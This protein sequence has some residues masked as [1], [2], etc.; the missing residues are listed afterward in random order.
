ME[1]NIKASR[2]LTKEEKEAI[3][4]CFGYEVVFDNLSPRKDY[5][6]YYYS[7][8]RDDYEEEELTE[9][10]EHQN[11]IAAAGVCG[12]IDKLLE[13]DKHAY[14][15]IEGFGDWAMRELKAKDFTCRIYSLDKLPYAIEYWKQR[16]SDVKVMS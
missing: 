1:V 16:D 10:Q 14:T 6:I 5:V 11:R 7:V 15:W 13:N 3:E 9:K 4:D 12:L 8:G 2:T